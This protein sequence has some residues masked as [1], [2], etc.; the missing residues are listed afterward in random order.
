M[1]LEEIYKIFEKLDR[2]ALFISKP[3]RKQDGAG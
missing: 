3:V 1:I 2:G